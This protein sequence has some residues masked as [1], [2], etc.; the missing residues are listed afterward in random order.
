M[1]KVLRNKNYCNELLGLL[2]HQYDDYDNLMMMMGLEKNWAGASEMIHE[3]PF[4]SQI[5][6]SSQF[7]NYSSFHR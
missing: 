7:A 2:D 5:L 1:L 6:P 3:N 4:S